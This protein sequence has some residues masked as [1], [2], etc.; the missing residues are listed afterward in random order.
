[1][2]IRIIIL[3]YFCLI[4]NNSSFAQEQLTEH[5]L[6]LN[7]GSKGEPA[8]IEDVAWIAGRLVRRGLEQTQSWHN[9][10]HVSIDSRK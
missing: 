10:G 2:T 8:K 3:F 6:K 5:T 1:M 9:D 7:E 4:Y